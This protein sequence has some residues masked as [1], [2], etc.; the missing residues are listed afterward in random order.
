MCEP[1]PKGLLAFKFNQEV[2]RTTKGWE[3]ISYLIR[4][5]R[6]SDYPGRIDYKLVRKDGVGAEIWVDQD[7]VVAL[8]KSR[9]KVS[10]SAEAWARGLEC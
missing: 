3:S 1:V 9:V 4:G 7:Q 5:A 8:P 10:G 2:R 6:P